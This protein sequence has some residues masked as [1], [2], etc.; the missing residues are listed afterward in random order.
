M[1][2]VKKVIKKD[3]KLPEAFKDIDKL[4]RVV[5]VREKGK[6]KNQDIIVRFKT[7]HT[8]YQVFNERKKAKS[9]NI[10]L[11]L[12]KKRNDLLYNASVL[13]DKIG[14][15]QFVFTTTHGDL[16]VRIAETHGCLK[17]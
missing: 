5:K 17:T 4:H 7:D 10:R 16:Y 2:F 13:V 6:K 3:L 8:R 9:S 11:N 14:Q 1:N 12:T 15:V